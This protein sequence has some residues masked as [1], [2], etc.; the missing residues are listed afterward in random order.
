MA[1]AALV[2]AGPAICSPA[3]AMIEGPRPRPR[4]V[5]QKAI[6]DIARPRT[7][8]GASACSADIPQTAPAAEENI[9]DH[10]PANARGAEPDANTQAPA[11]PPRSEP[12]RVGNEGVRT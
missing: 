4:S 11:P 9:K 10:V 5:L 8:G 6:I 1:S 2:A 3:T 7:G 12:G